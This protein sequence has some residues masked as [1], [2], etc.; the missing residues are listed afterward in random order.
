MR[1]VFIDGQGNRLD[2]AAVDDGPRRT[3]HEYP[4]NYDPITLWKRP[5]SEC[6]GTVYTDRLLSW[7]AEKYREL[8]QKHLPDVRWDNAHF[9]A[10]QSFLRDWFGE[11]KLF[12][13]AVIE[14]CNQATG[15]P[16]WRL[17]YWSQK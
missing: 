6:N 5:E 16:T 10:I 8:C 2:M 17:D 9:T 11:Q 4:Y 7:D 3:K 12:L 13:V 15:Y 1:E 14:Y